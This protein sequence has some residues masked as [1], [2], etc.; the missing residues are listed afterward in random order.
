MSRTIPPRA[1]IDYPT[2]DGKPLAEN[3]P[4]LHAIHFQSEQG[5]NRRRAELGWP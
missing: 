2:G 1:A 3:D 5:G 4:Q